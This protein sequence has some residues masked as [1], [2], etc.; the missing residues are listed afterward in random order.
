M[1]E[2]NNVVN[3]SRGKAIEGECKI[4]NKLN[5]LI[6]LCLHCNNHH[7]GMSYLNYIIELHIIVVM[8]WL[9][10]IE[11]YFLYMECYLWLLYMEC[12]LLHMEWDHESLDCAGLRHL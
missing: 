5:S 10:K 6:N 9:L 4:A 11:G 7:L 12:N 1:Y 2:L 3:I 8:T